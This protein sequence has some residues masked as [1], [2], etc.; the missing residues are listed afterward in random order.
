MEAIKGHRRKVGYKALVN[1]YLVQLDETET[2]RANPSPTLIAEEDL[3]TPI[4]KYLAELPPLMG[5]NFQA[6]TLNSLCRRIM[7]VSEEELLR[8]ITFYLNQIFPPERKAHPRARQRAPIKLSKRKQRRSEYARVQELFKKD[9]GR[10]IQNIVDNISKG[11]QPPRDLMEPF[12]LAVMSNHETVTSVSLNNCRQGNLNT[13]WSPILPEEIKPCLPRVKSA[14][15]PDGVTPRLLRSVP[16][17][18]LSRLYCILMICSNVPEYLLKSRTIFIPK[19]S[20]S[21]SPGDFRPLTISSVVIRCLNKVL[22]R[23]L[24][25]SIPLDLRQR[26]F[27]KADGCAEATFYLDLVLRYHNSK[28]KNLYIASIDISKAFDSVSHQA[29]LAALEC[30]DVPKPLASYIVNIYEKS[31]TVL[32]GDDW[33]S[34]PVHPV[35]GVKQGDPLSPVLFNLIMDSLLRSLPT[36]VGINIASFRMNALAYADDLLLFASTRDGLEELL[37][38]ASSFFNSCGM[39]INT[40]KSF[41]IALRADGKNKKIAVDG[42]VRIMCENRSLPALR[43][44][45]TFNYLGVTF[46]PEGRV[47]CKP[48]E[49]IKPLLDAL[50]AAPLKPQQRLWA[51]R[52]VVLPRL[53]HQLILGSVMIG[54]L[55]KTDRTVRNSVRNWVNLPHDTP[56]AYFHAAM[57]DG[58]LGIPA[59]R[60]CIPLWRLRRLRSLASSVLDVSGEL[61]Y[62]QEVE[63]CQRRLHV[64]NEHLDNALGIR[65]YWAQKLY[66]S[67]DG[68]ALRESSGVG[69]QHSWVERANRL[70]SGRDFI[71][72]IRL[73]INA[74]PTKSR[75]S[76]GRLRDRRCRAGCLR[77]E[78]MNHILQ[79]CHRTH[80]ERI[81]RH[82]AVVSFVGRNLARAGYIV[83]YEPPYP[84]EEGVRKP[85]VVAVMGRTALLLDGQVVSDMANLQKAHNAKVSYYARNTQLINQIKN[86]S[87]ASDV[88]VLSVTLSWR[89]VWCPKSATELLSIGAINKKDLCIIASRVLIGGIAAFRT[90]N[91]RTAL[92]AHGVANRRGIG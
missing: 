14:A 2:L 80:N 49:F 74:F 29:I 84:T 11:R 73:R 65:H 92:V 89:G 36:E 30:R 82:N 42:A 10:C 91:K 76:R 24:Q 31:R 64:D 17:D 21:V 9:P 48:Q 23:R 87:G 69:P 18:I 60:W 43:R 58:G 47:P 83:R 77:I 25:N 19:K 75:T 39:S 44:T 41:V 55:R 79:A 78:N 40:G 34:T 81:R 27:I 62:R 70:L 15:G 68:A 51:L 45:D 90:F 85:D 88:K 6:K 38:S 1:S 61:Y 56:V 4:R 71:N 35:R 12:W 28:L 37:N 33:Q 59:M 52:L 16:M 8:E 5:N 26:G 7:T 67:V 50:S 13:L 3:T 54:S 46:S 20:N 53:Y 86:E 72:C 22:A 63:R 57:R 66:S 32:V